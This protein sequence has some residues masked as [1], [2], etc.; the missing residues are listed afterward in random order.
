MQ[1]PSA[2]RRPKPHTTQKSSCS[3]AVRA[4]TALGSRAANLRVHL[5]TRLAGIIRPNELVRERAL[6]GGKVTQPTDTLRA[7]GCLSARSPAHI[8]HPAHTRKGGRKGFNPAYVPDTYKASAW[9]HP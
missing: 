4:M 3:R 9:C 6:H 5:A 7:R 1:N 2:P 8:R